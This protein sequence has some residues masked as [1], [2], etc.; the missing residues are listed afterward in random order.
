MGSLHQLG[1]RRRYRA[2]VRP[3]NVRESPQSALISGAES[4]SYTVTRPPYRRAL[5]RY[6]HFQ[7]IP[8]SIPNH[9]TVHA[10]LTLAD[11]TGCV[12]AQ[13]IEMIVDRRAARKIAYVKRKG[14]LFS[15][16][17]VATLESTSVEKKRRVRRAVPRPRR[18]GFDN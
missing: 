2:S 5:V 7:S 10:N 4:E 3:S 18:S 13:D 14:R 8:K 6:A 1:L 12:F 16:R 9:A 17:D 11:D 15:K